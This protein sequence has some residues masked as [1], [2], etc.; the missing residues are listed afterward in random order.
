MYN[1]NLYI[2][3]GGPG[4]GKT[5][6]LH[7][8]EKR[9]YLCVAEVARE[10]IQEQVLTGGDALPWDDALS[11]A[12][13]MLARSV[14][15]YRNNRHVRAFCFFDRGVPDTIAYARLTGLVL[16]D[17]ANNV[18]SECRY[19][20]IVFLFPPWESIYRTDRE[21]KQN[22]QIAVETCREIERTYENLG[23]ELIRVPLLSPSQRSDF[24]LDTI[25][26]RDNYIF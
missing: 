2:L 3:T 24:I 19:N 18:V 20:R 12:G 11:Y 9:G 23:Y 14:R 26:K 7:E 25:Q 22:F 17:E 8:L 16:P 6:V 15:D 13:F 4:A 1:L 5:T 21:R 10:I